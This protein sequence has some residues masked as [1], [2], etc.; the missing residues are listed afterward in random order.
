MKKLILAIAFTTLSVPALSQALAPALPI[1]KTYTE[2]F[3]SIF[4]VVNIVQATTGILY[5][6][7]VPFANL[8][9]YNSNINSSVDTSNQTHF[10]QSYSEL[11]RSAFNTAVRPTWTVEDFEKQIESNAITNTVDVGI[12]HYN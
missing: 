5:E 11:Y 3:D 6:R 9:N 7:V 2:M 8:I 1:E 4:S 10:I 12:L